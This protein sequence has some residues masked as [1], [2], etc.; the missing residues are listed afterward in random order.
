MPELLIRPSVFEPLDWL[1]CAITTRH[2]SNDGESRTDLAARLPE[3]AGLG[4]ME[5]VVGQQVHDCKIACVSECHDPAHSHEQPAV[6]EDS[7]SGKESRCECGQSGCGHREHVP[8]DRGL[9]QLVEIPGVDGLLTSEA[10]IML[11]IHTAD[12]VPIVLADRRTRAVSVVH[13][14]RE[15][16]RLGIVT[17]ILRYLVQTGSRPADLLAWIGPAICQDHYEVSVAIAEQFRN[18]FDSFP[19]VVNGR[20][21]ALSEISRRLLLQSGVPPRQIEVDGRCTFENPDLFYSYRRD[22]A[23]AGRMATFAVRRS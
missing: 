16:T 13:A 17:K 4:R 19:G 14:G 23:A 7:E 8:E 20:R 5:V 11:A 10:H 18:Q 21:L 15:G 3:L 6:V 9:S 22:G 1:F 12:C 2:A